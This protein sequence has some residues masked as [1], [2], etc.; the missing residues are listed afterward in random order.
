[1]VRQFDQLTQGD[2]MVV[3]NRIWLFLTDDD[4]IPYM[5]CAIVALFSG[6]VIFPAAS[7]YTARIERVEAAL[8]VGRP[9]AHKASGDSWNGPEMSVETEKG[10][11]RVAGSM[12]LLKD[13]SMT[14]ESRGN[15]SRWLCQNTPKECSHVLGAPG[16][17]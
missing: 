1:V 8:D 15:G 11:F 12:E 2:A 16:Q 6:A 4:H 7:W 10:F 13:R 14:L 9:V 3:L 17:P 5:A